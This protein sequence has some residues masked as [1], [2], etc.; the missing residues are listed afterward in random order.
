MAELLN[1]RKACL[2]PHHPGPAGLHRR[3]KEITT[4]RRCDWGTRW[5]SSSRS[6]GPARNTPP[7]GGRAGVSAH[8]KACELSHSL[9]PA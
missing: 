1:A 5:R 7:W 9:T 6:T 3:R 8:A 4:G 2:G